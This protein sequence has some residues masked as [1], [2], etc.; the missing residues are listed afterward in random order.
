MSPET[1][2]APSSSEGADA[3]NTRREALEL[4]GWGVPFRFMQPRNPCFWVYLAATAWGLFQFCQQMSHVNL[5]FAS[6]VT[7]I[8]LLGIY[9]ALLGW[10][11]SKV[12]RYNR[13]PSKLL[14]AAW[15]WGGLAATFGLAII[16]NDAIS[17]I[18]A[19]LF[20]S[21]F[22]IDWWA[23]LSAPFVEETSKAAGF[24]LLLGLA[25]RRIRSLCD[26]LLI[27][28]FLGLGFEILEDL[29]YIVNSAVG[30]SGA[31]QI[32]AVF[33]MYFVRSSTGFFSHALYTALFS[34]GLVFLLGTP[35]VRRNVGGGI[36]LMVA[37]VA[38]HGVWDGA[39]AIGD[40]GV[41][42]IVVMAV[43]VL[44]SALV[45]IY[46]YRLGSAQEREWM[47]DVLRPEVDS[48]V[49]TEG[50]MEAIAGTFKEKRA[51]LKASRKVGKRRGKRTARKIVRTGRGLA[52]ELANSA[53]EDSPKVDGIRAEIGHLRAA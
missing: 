17:E 48:G 27:G 37:A 42:T 50:E 9:G 45:F 24:L 19:K 26:A 51:F 2:P 30:S 32:R 8:I 41:G 16:A 35:V 11:F 33:N 38:A 1:R 12:N 5:E 49:M 29:I 13:Q 22:V 40:G 28:A 43:I 20:G 31:D 7:V 15:I 18:Y 39:G 6:V 36:F 34:A 23:A 44:A 10:L 52:R 47:R 3:L 53:G 46:I 25:P 4:S 21:A 14:M